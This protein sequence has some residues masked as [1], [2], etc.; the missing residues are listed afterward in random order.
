M[1][2]KKLIPENNIVIKGSVELSSDKSLSIRAILFSSIAHG[3]STIKINNPGEDAQTSIMAIKTLGIK[4]KK[5]GSNYII[6][7]L[8]IG[9]PENKKTLWLSFK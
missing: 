9:Y 7:G 5:K 3:I 2:I 1:A 8:G 6:F 4:V